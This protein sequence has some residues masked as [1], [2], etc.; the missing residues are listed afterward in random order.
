MSKPHHSKK[1]SN[2]HHHHKNIKI[3][4]VYNNRN[5]NSFKNLVLEYAKAI[6]MLI[7]TAILLFGMWF[8]VEYGSKLIS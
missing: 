2:V 1:H 5:R 4:K 8:V 7:I 6:A 3:V